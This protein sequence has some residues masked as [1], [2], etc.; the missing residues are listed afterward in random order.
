MWSG[1][2]TVIP[3]DSP[4]HLGWMSSGGPMLAVLCAVSHAVK[5]FSLQGLV[6]HWRTN[7]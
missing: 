2:E 3:I 7:C 1:G 6:H 5:S 4:I